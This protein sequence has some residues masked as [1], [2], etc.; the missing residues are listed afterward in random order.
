[1]RRPK[2]APLPVG[3]TPFEAVR[4]F[5]MIAVQVDAMGFDLIVPAIPDLIREMTGGGLATAAL[6]S[7]VMATILSVMQFLFDPVLGGLSG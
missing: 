7:G 1:M 3:L 2:P 4:R 5:I 6:W